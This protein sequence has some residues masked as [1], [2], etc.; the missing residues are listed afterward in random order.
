MLSM[1]V[2]QIN[3]GCIIGYRPSNSTEDYTKLLVTNLRYDLEYFEIDGY[4]LVEK[5]IGR[6]EF[7]IKNSS[8][9]ECKFSDDIYIASNIRGGFTEITEKDDVEIVILGY[10]DYDVLIELSNFIRNYHYKTIKSLKENKKKIRYSHTPHIGEI[11]NL[12]FNH[13][14]NIFIVTEVDRVIGYT[15]DPIE[16][17]FEMTAIPLSVFQ[18]DDIKDRLI[19]TINDAE[20][21][22]LLVDNELSVSFRLNGYPSIL[23]DNTICAIN[24]ALKS[25]Q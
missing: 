3:V 23:P 21:L 15:Y 7:C 10:V 19:T 1:K 8:I 24:D 14:N 4:L 9:K 20:K 13:N 12:P 25:N 17:V 5:G 16:D 6:D 22:N 11:Y 18:T 2:N